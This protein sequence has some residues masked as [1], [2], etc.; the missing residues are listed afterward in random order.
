MLRRRSLG[1]WLMTRPQSDQADGSQSHP[2]DQCLDPP[3]SSNSRST[4]LQSGS[5]SSVTN[6][7]SEPIQPIPDHFGSVSTLDC[8]PS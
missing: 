7:T 2:A 5:V 3:P 1:P 8:Q 4:L 6:S